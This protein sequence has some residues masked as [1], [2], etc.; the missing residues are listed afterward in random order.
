MLKLLYYYPLSPSISCCHLM[1]P[2]PLMPQPPTLNQLR[3]TGH[4]LSRWP[5]VSPLLHCHISFLYIL[6][7]IPQTMWRWTG[8]CTYQEWCDILHIKCILC[9]VFNPSSTLYH[10]HPSI[11]CLSL[12]C[13]LTHWLLCKVSLGSFFPLF[14]F[15]CP[16]AFSLIWS[17]CHHCCLIWFLCHC[18]VHYRLHAV[19]CAAKNWPNSCSHYLKTK[20]SRVK[21][22]WRHFSNF[23]PQYKM[24]AKHWI[25]LTVIPV[26]I[27]FFW[28]PLLLDVCM[29][30]YPIHVLWFGPG[31]SIALATGAC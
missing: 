30:A 27:W 7:Y 8:Y 19:C 23:W 11:H 21:L 1:L 18:F 13:P 20:G 22:H 26:C 25:L 12:S 14:C 3:F 6:L 5:G 15:V 2:Q 16:F 24:I 4:S 9:L 29:E 17:F 10:H 28:E 31:C